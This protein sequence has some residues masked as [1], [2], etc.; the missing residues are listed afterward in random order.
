MT[1]EEV[2]TCNRTCNQGQVSLVG[3]G[4]YTTQAW[5]GSRRALLCDG[6]LEPLVQSPCAGPR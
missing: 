1:K 4:M 6:L 3:K 2:H 5:Q